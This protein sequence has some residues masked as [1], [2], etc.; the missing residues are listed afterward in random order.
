MAAYTTDVVAVAGGVEG[1]VRRSGGDDIADGI[2]VAAS[3]VGGKG[4]LDHV[5]LVTHE[6]EHCT[7]QIHSLLLL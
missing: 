2:V 3:I 6:V 5:V 7:I 1:D 4:Y